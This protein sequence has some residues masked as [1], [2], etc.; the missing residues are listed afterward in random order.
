MN[1]APARLLRQHV[2][3]TLSLW[4]ALNV[5]NQGL[6]G[7]FHPDLPDY[8]RCLA[9]TCFS[10]KF[11]MIATTT[12]GLKSYLTLPRCIRNKTDVRSNIDNIL[13]RTISPSL[14]N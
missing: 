6:W 8:Q 2:V 1:K 10:G 11:W 13:T 9:W 4:D 12:P 3:F 14:S 7:I 5:D